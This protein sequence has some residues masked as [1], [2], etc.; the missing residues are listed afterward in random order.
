MSTVQWRAIYRHFVER[1]EANE[2]EEGMLLPSEIDVAAHWGVSRQTANKAL[3]ALQQDGLVIRKRRWGTVVAGPAAKVTGRF[4]LV[5]DLFAQD[6]GFPQPDLI[7]GIQDGLGEEAQ[8][9]VTEA[10]HEGERELRLIRKL[11][12]ECDGILWWPVN[13][14][15]NT[16]AI[17]RMVDNGTP[18]VVLDRLPEGL[19]ADAVMSDHEGSSLRA[20]REL[21]AR[22]HRKI[23]FLSFHRPQLSSVLE[24]HRAY[25]TALA[26]VGVTDYER[27][28][29]WFHSDLEAERNLFDQAVADAVLALV[30]KE[31]ISALFC[32]QDSLAVA[33]ID[34]C[35]RLGISVPDQLEIA[36]FN[37][38]PSMLLRAP[39]S[40][41]RIVQRHHELGYQAA[42]RLRQRIQSPLAPTVTVRVPAD[43]FPADAGI[44]RVGPD[45][46]AMSAQFPR[47]KEGSI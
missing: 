30:Q 26:E 7:R 45:P 21:E 8:I 11:A 22:G 37:D 31:G 28:E 15:R 41:H 38:W 1:I 18:I 46:A 40:M 16:A 3:H 6:Y 24:R 4:A 14:P 42:L 10:R 44:A 35:G 9:V 5:V 19:G 25:V 47:T 27:F 33:A 39:W 20:L 13:D 23:G 17:Q 29:R 43:F 34:A 12:D 36:T 32:V 2:L